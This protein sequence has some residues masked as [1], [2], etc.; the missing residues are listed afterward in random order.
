MRADAARSRELILD[1]ARQI[2]ADELRLNDLARASGV[3]VA[4]VYR[5]FPTVI[6]VLEALNSSAIDE[7]V[8]AARRAVHSN[9]AGTAFVKLVRKAIELQVSHGGLQNVLISDEVSAE[10]LTR[11]DEFFQ[12]ATRVLDTA[13]A[14]GSIHHEV[15]IEHVHHLVC[16]IEH[17][18]RLGEG[19]N[20][21][22]MIDILTSGLTGLQKRAR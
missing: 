21:M 22:L 17:A 19:R 20:R 3:G 5:H 12:L 16:G 13:T 6:A 18:I 14:D 8:M 2:P 15:T 10:T 11:R 4:T 9:D 1:T 7:L